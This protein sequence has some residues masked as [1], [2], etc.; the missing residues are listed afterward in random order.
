ME[1]TKKHPHGS[2]LRPERGA[3]RIQE[4]AVVL[5]GTVFGRV[6]DYR[7]LELLVCVKTPNGRLREGIED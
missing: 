5:E 4:V 6:H 1:L 3:T 2:R 7:P